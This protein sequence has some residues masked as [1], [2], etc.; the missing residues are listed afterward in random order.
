MITNKVDRAV[1]WAVVFV[2]ALLLAA[3][4]ACVGDENDN[5]V[6]DATP[7]CIRDCN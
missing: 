7:F 2:L 6:T 1:F 4:M 3:S 5:R